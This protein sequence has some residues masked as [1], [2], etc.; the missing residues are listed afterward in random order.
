M[1]P[2]QLFAA[3]ADLAPASGEQ[4][5]DVGKGGQPLAWLPDTDRP[6]RS[7]TVDRLAALD[8]LHREERVLRRGWAWLLGT[9]EVGGIRRR[10]RLPLLVQPVRIERALRTRLVPAGDLELTPL[11]TD[12]TIAA[13]FEAAPGIGSTGWLTAPGTVAWITAAA[14]AAGLPVARVL[15]ATL[16]TPKPFKAPKVAEDELVGYAGTAL[17]VVRDVT[18]AGLRD[19]LLNWSTRPELGSTALAAVYSGPSAPSAGADTG[20]IRSPLPLNAAQREVV[21]RT[22]RER[23][24]VVSGPPGN[25]KSHAVVAAAL[26]TVDRGGSVLVAT[27]SGYA[28]EVLGGLLARYPGPVPVQFGDA[29]RREAIATELAEGTGLGADRQQ[30][31][32]DDDAVRAAESKVDDIVHGLEAALALERQAD[33]LVTWAPLLA[34]LQ[35]D[36]PN[37]FESGFN[38]A[39]PSNAGFAHAGSAN[40]GSANAG[41]ANA[42]F[43]NAGFDLAAADRLYRRATQAGEGWWWRLWRGWALRR[44]RERT[45]AA[46]T[47]PL[48]R[49][50][51]GLEAFRAVS[52]AA[53]LASTGGTDLGP[54]WAGLVAADEALAGAVA[55]AMRNR[56]TSAQR[57]SAEARRSAAALANALRA[58]RNRR[59]ETLAALD[60]AALVRALPLWVGTVTDVEDLLPATPGLFDLVILDE[61]AHIDQ[62][63]AAPVLARAKRALV[64]GDARQLRFVSF[65]ADVDI[66]ATLARHGLSGFADRLDVRRSSAF[67]VATGAAPVTYLEEHYRSRPHLIEFSAKRFYGDRIALMTRHPRDEQ[68]DIIDVRRVNDAALIDG[69]NRAEIEA[70]LREVRELAAASGGGAGGAVGVGAGGI[71]VITPFRAQADALE[72]ALLDA[73]PVDEIERLGLR[74]GTVHAFQGSEADTV[75]ASLGLVEGDSSARHRFVG[76]ANLFNVLVTRARQRMLV[77][78]SLV[79]ASGIVA[80]YL[81]YSLAPPE[82]VHRPLGTVGDPADSRAGILAGNQ[83]D[84]WAVRLGRELAESG[85]R[86]RADYP[87]GRWSVD[88]CVAE[89]GLICRPH[90]DGAAAHIERQRA[91]L[92][93][94][95]TLHDAFAS[96]WSGSVTRAA[97]ELATELKRDVKKT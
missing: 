13:T 71:G 80:D 35:A 38:T 31:S 48:E 30:L 89:V 8:A 26:D 50:R 95:W 60:G 79:D 5:L 75:V 72:A 76:D 32:H 29:E 16:E 12:R 33:E 2:S 11:I 25:G 44:L 73:F 39:D 69:V 93:A 17:F 77:V 3:L 87:V 7:R 61:A 86:V 23:V 67:D 36:L 81:A 41:F 52:G 97:L 51:A 57:W 63:R 65:V 70:V 43:D 94:G 14:E 62:I 96:R 37:T 21:R 59:R 18:S 66:A 19:T 46:A 27:Q 53:R 1:Q 74:V 82:P 90:P 42:R 40:A 24:V 64:V 15:P 4:V 84:D 56:A 34:G 58:G 91:L 45:G 49:L 55:T 83:A 10:V 22:R 54:A 6:P 92:R 88:L 20:P 78:T 28:A 9:A 68:A 47:V 85:L